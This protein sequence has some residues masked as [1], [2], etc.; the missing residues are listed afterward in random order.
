VLFLSQPRPSLA[1]PPAKE[2]ALAKIGM[3]SAAENPAHDDCS[4]C[5]S[6]AVGLS[7]RRPPLSWD[8]HCKREGTRLC[9]HSVLRC[10]TLTGKAPGV[11]RFDLHERAF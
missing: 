3:L 6:P 8:G 2:S 9:D 7:L 5:C 1:C 11:A 4:P 10:L